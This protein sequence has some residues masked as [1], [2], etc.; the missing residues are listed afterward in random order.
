MWVRSGRSSG[1]GMATP[2]RAPRE[3]HGQRDLEGYGPQ[4]RKELDMTEA[5]QQAH[6]ISNYTLKYMGTHSC[7]KSWKPVLG[8]YTFTL[9]SHIY[10]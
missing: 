7:L 8:S 5:T 6:K 1:G 4:G 9:H 10:I 3:S 2:S